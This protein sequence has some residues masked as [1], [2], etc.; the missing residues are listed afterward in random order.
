MESRL[1]K[2]G[3]AVCMLFFLCPLSFIIP[4]LLFIRIWT[5]DDISRFLGL[6]IL[7]SVKI[8]PR[9]TRRRKKKKVGDVFPPDPFLIHYGV[10][11]ELQ[12]LESYRTLREECLDFYREKNDPVR[13]CLL[14]TSTRPGE[15]K[16]TCTANLAISF[17][18]TGR[19][20]LLMDAD[21]RLGRIAPMLAQPHKCGMT[22][23]LNSGFS[24][25]EETASQLTEYILPTM[26]VN[27]SILPKGG[28]DEAAGELM[29]SDK[30]KTII[31]MVRGKYDIVLIDTPPL[32]TPDS[33]SIF[34]EV[35]G[36]IFVC[37]SGLTLVSEAWESVRSIQQRK[38]KIATV[39]NGTHITPFQDNQYK[40]Y[41]YYYKTGTMP[42]KKKTEAGKNSKSKGKKPVA[43]PQEHISHYF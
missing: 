17:A 8:H 24:S 32:I 26:Q 21:F 11:Y 42:G 36:V 40:K 9:I 15:G 12:D 22:E 13:L 18:R 35:D 1:L 7:T 23:I 41:G 31:R 28:D 43:P 5:R 39:L 27:L 20:V 10:G 37:C 19:K 6:R 16:S 2:A 33:L 38:I 25:E 4:Q 3:V 14:T 30:L 34:S 29:G